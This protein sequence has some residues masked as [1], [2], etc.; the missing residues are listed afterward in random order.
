MRL[1][2]WHEMGRKL[3]SAKG[4]LEKGKGTQLRKRIK[5]DARMNCEDRGAWKRILL[6]FR[7][8]V[9]E[10]GTAIL[11]GKKGQ[12]ERMNNC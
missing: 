10:K 12:K 6:V 5:V 3:S 2:A 1:I 9:S 8:M 7:R 4:R 11:G